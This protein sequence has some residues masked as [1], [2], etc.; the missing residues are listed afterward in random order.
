MLPRILLGLFGLL[1]LGNGLLMLA[2]PHLWYETVP[3]VVATGPFN[4]HFVIDIAL[5]YV[6]SGAFMLAGFSE[7]RGAAAFALA[8]AAW[9]ALHALFHI[10]G[11]IADGFP[12]DVINA[13]TQVVGVVLIGFL[14]VALAV[15][16]ATL[17]EGATHD[18]VLSAQEAR[19]DGAR[20]RL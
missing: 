9:P 8:G 14:G 4:H 13:A 2:A 16:R 3:G 18:Q 11:W 19:R 5:A 6:A 12:A 1:N 7:R 10:L 17:N 20:V 15:W